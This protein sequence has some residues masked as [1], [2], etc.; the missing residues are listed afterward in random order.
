MPQGRGNPYCRL[1]PLLAPCRTM[2]P[3]MYHC[4]CTEFCHLVFALA[5]HSCALLVACGQRW[6]SP[7][8]LPQKFF[9]VHHRKHSSRLLLIASLRLLLSPF[10]DALQYALPILVELQFCDNH[11]TGRDP[12]RNALPIALFPRHPLNVD[13]VF[14]AVDRGDFAIAAFVGAAYNGDF[15]VFA[16]GNG[17]NLL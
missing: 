12:Q 8:P 16:D 10:L 4:R 5:L 15:I 14:Q 9:P 13:H 1:T 3:G 2:S 11:F 7:D 6:P 17:S